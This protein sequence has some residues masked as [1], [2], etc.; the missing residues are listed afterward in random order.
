MSVHT[1][2]DFAFRL[3]E[4]ITNQTLDPK[5]YQRVHAD[6]IH[7]LQRFW[8]PLFH[9]IKKVKSHRKLQDA[10]DPDDLYTILWK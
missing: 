5:I 4:D 10:Q 2:S 9:Q 7:Q 3:V 6:M 8:N 1:D